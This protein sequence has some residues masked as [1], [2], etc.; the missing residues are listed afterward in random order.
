MMSPAMLRSPVIPLPGS[1]NAKTK[2][3][4]TSWCTSPS[5]W[6]MSPVMLV[7]SE[8]SPV[9]SWV[10]VLPMNGVMIRVPWV[11][12][13]VTRATKTSPVSTEKDGEE[14][15]K[16]TSTSSIVARGIPNAPGISPLM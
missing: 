4:G 2:L 6:G 3:T 9:R 7:G 8:E 15:V 16:R 10:M 1:E 13:R 11:A 14:L 12:V 5:E